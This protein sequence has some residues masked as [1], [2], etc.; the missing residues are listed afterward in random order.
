MIDQNLEVRKDER[1]Q[2]NKS[3]VG[4][5][6]TIAILLAIL[7]VVEIYQVVTSYQQTKLAEER[8][9]AYQTRVE[10]SQQLVAKQ[11]G[12]ILGLITSYEK[13]AYGENVDRIAE[14]QLIATEYS[15]T[16]LQIIAIQNSQII[17]L[18][19]NAP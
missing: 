11:Q 15:L 17:E 12:I 8:A 4:I 14:Q 13:D 7:L 9:S 2:H 19:A 1:P 16:A 3:Y 6:L 10:E 5:L 18:L